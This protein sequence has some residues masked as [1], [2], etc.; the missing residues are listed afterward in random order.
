MYRILAIFGL[1]LWLGLALQSFAVETTNEWSDDPNHYSAKANGWVEGTLM[2]AESDGSFGVRGAESPYARDYASF[3][4]EFFAE[5]PLQRES[6]R[7]ELLNSYGDRLK[8]PPSNAGPQRD[9]VFT[10]G[11]SEDVSISEEPQYGRDTNSWSYRAA[12]R[13]FRFGDLKTG[14]RVV[15]G[16][17][18]YDDQKAFT[19][20]LVNP[21]EISPAD[22][23]PK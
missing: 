12:P 10:G 11:N 16:Y 5:T 2:R 1:G 6:K 8:Y 19:I 23:R 4:R 14:D 21:N 22:I 15:V 13:R 7:Q 20:Y 9:Y 17:D 18:T 3:H